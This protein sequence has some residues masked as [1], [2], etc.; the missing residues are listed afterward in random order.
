L[1]RAEMAI[2]E[3]REAE[4]KTAQERACKCGA[5]RAQI[6][7]MGGF[8]ACNGQNPEKRGQNLTTAEA[9][10]IRACAECDAEKGP[11]ACAKEIERLTISDAELA[12]YIETVHIPRCGRP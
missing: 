9:D 10:E 5:E 12:K 3:N 11:A 4:S 6:P 1:T 2:Q 7:I 8:L